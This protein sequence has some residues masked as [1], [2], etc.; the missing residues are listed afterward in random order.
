MSHNMLEPL[1][2][3]LIS[4]MKGRSLFCR[5]HS[6]YGG[7]L[8]LA[9]ARPFG[10][11]DTASCANFTAT[12]LSF[13]QCRV[14]QLFCTTTDFVGCTDHRNKRLLA[15]PKRCHH[16]RPLGSEPDRQPPRFLLRPRSPTMAPPSPHTIEDCSARA[17]KVAAIPLRR[18]ADVA[19]SQHCVLAP[20][21]PPSC[22]R[23]LPCG[24][25]SATSIP[26]PHRCTRL[27]NSRWRRLVD[28]LDH[29]FGTSR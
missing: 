10:C 27:C 3:V 1:E 2:M 6:I 15:R 28:L 23:A 8:F 19:S 16:Q 29:R 12:F 26:Q 7:I 5:S 24:P 22:C 14:H 21:S 13:R 18:P 11:T 9:P 4:A 17:S 25:P 20:A